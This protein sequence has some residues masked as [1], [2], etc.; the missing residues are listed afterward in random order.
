MQGVDPREPIGRPKRMWVD[1]VSSDLRSL[2]TE[3]DWMVQT[4]NKVRG[5]I[6]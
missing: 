4:T 2:R 6:W 1:T 3:D 5:G